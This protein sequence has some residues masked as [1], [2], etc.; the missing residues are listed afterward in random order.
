MV[1]NYLMN[2]P[3]T[4]GHPAFGEGNTN[5]QLYASGNHQDGNRNGSWTAPR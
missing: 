4:G 2:G 3:S 1:N 5:F